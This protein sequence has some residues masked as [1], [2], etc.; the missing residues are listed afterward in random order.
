MGIYRIL[1]MLVNIALLIIC[2]LTDPRGICREE[3]RALLFVEVLLALN[4][5]GLV[6]VLR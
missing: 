6:G 3:K 5:I 4:T 1:V 2:L